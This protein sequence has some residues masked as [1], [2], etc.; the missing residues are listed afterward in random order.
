M[1]VT[2]CCHLT[3]AYSNQPAVVCRDTCVHAVPLKD[4]SVTKLHQIIDVEH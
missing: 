4:N 3:N 2:S 1:V